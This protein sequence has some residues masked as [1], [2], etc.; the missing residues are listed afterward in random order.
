MISNTGVSSVLKGS[1]HNTES[2]FS[3]GPSVISSQVEIKKTQNPSI[4]GSFESF[5]SPD[6]NISNKCWVCGKGFTLKKKHLCKFCN[7]TVCSEHSSRTRQ[8]PGSTE[9]LRICDLC[10][11]DKAKEDIKEEINTEL[12]KL[13]ENAANSRTAIERLNREYFEKTSILNDA[14]NKLSCIEAAHEKKMKDMKEELERVRMNIEKTTVLMTSAR[15]ALNDAKESQ[16]DMAAKCEKAEQETRHLE[17][18]SAGLKKET[19]ELTTKIDLINNALKTSI[20]FENI[21]K[22]LCT[23]CASRLSESFDR[24]KSTSYWLQEPED[25]L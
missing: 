9:E 17:E 19:T 5:S 7:N 6:V 12:I 23:R 21:S 2:T 25:R 24:L 20:L 18:K 11:Q 15:K 16:E 4:K 22:S 8:R 14:E 1:L 13:E 3:G 10:E